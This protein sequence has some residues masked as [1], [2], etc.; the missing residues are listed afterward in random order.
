MDAEQDNNENVEFSYNLGSDLKI[1][2]DA[3]K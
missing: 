2:I 3:A 1:D